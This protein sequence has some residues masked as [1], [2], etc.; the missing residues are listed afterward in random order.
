MIH[1]GGTLHIQYAFLSSFYFSSR[2]VGSNVAAPCSKQ[3]GGAQRQ[4]ALSNK[5]TQQGD[6]MENMETEKHN[7]G[8]MH[9]LP[10]TDTGCGGERPQ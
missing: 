2:L 1:L 6:N 9:T 3:R 8:R 10:K 4:Q 5:E 7:L